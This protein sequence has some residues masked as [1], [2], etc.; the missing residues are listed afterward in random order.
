VLLSILEGYPLKAHQ[1]AY[2]EERY[3]GGAAAVL[4]E[5]AIVMKQRQNYRYILSLYPGDRKICVDARYF[6]V[7]PGRCNW[8]HIVGIDYWNYS[9]ACGIG[10]PNIG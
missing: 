5:G 8:V 7:K 1:Y 6:L 9:T 3:M 10:T 4:R 2:M